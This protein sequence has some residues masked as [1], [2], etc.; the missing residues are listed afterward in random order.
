MNTT[1]T[2]HAKTEEV[3]HKWWVID[4]SNQT[5]GRLATQVTNIIRG[6]MKPIY[7]PNADTGDFV[8][9]INSDKMSLS[10]KKWD[11]KKYYRHSRFFGSMKEM[12]AAQHKVK[13]ST[14]I[15]NE[16]VRGML[17]KNKMAYTLINKLKI[18]ATG[19]H[20]HAAQKP[21]LYEIKRGN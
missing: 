5:V 12:T 6:K 14:F 3:D 4:A 16:A 2:W 17:P 18:Y 1:G 7:T 20:P 9:V 19:E 15:L 10:G 13:D 11:E 8:V 21:A